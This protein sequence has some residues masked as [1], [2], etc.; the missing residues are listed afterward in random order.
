MKKYLVLLIFCLIIDVAYSLELKGN[1]ETKYKTDFLTNEDGKYIDEDKRYNG[2]LDINGNID[3][4]LENN[5]HLMNTFE[6]RPI[7]KRVYNGSYG[8]HR[9]ITNDS[10]LNDDFYGKENYLKRNEL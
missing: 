3:L 4:D 5:F 8:N 1:I 7:Q 9:P 10:T 2:Y 6:L